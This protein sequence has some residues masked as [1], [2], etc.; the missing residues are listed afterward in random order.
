VGGAG[1]ASYA[2]QASERTTEE[3][4]QPVIVQCAFS[5]MRA[6]PSCV[7]ISALECQTSPAS[8]Q[9]SAQLAFCTLRRMCVCIYIYIHIYAARVVG[10]CW[11]AEARNLN[12]AGE[13]RMRFGHIDRVGQN[14]IY[15]VYIRY[16]W[17][18]NHQ[19]YGVYIRIY[20]V[21]ANPTYRC[22]AKEVRSKATP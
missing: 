16:F 18:G 17:L 10:E 21:L 20:T 7:S 14:H 2:R 11:R 8:S 4:Q 6:L 9:L 12:L 15:T 22:E 5:I 13:E 1:Q 19:I 3:I